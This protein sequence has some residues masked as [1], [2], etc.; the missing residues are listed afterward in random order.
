M[1]DR[2]RDNRHPGHQRDLLYLRA[3]YAL[4]HPSQLLDP[5]RGGELYSAGPAA[6]VPDIL[7]DGRHKFLGGGEERVV[8][9]GGRERLAVERYIFAGG[10]FQLLSDQRFQQSSV[11]PDEFHLGGQHCDDLRDCSV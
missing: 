9:V 3:A 2:Y 8:G 7:A 1:P 6:C 10:V 4:P 11:H 5:G